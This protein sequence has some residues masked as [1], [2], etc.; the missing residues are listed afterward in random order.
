MGSTDIPPF[1]REKMKGKAASS[2]GNIPPFLKDKNPQAVDNTAPKANT[3]A[4][5]PAPTSTTPAPEPQVV[6]QRFK[7]VLSSDNILDR[8]LA[9]NSALSLSSFNNKQAPALSLTGFNQKQSS[10]LSLTPSFEASRHNFASVVKSN[11]E[12]IKEYKAKRLEQLDSEE[13]DHVATIERI[14]NET[15]NGL[16]LSGSQEE[17]DNASKKL[18]EVQTYK[19]ELVK[20]IDDQAAKTLGGL[21]PV[22]TPYLDETG[23]TKYKREYKPVGSTLNDGA[24]EAGKAVNLSYLKDMGK[25]LLEVTNPQEAAKFDMGGDTP[26]LSQQAEFMGVYARS[27]YL[28]DQIKNKTAELSSDPN[29]ANALNDYI[30]KKATKEQI[31]VLN[32]EGVK[33]LYDEYSTL[34]KYSNDI[35]HQFPEIRK[36]FLKKAIFNELDGRYGANNGF[37]GTQGWSEGQVNS[38]VSDYKKRLTD[39]RDIQLLDS[40]NE[41]KELGF[42]S[43]DNQSWAMKMAEQFGTT[44]WNTG[45]FLKEDVIKSA[46]PK[47]ASGILP[48]VS[49]DFNNINS[50]NRQNALSE[51]DAAKYTVNP[52]FKLDRKTFFLKE[53]V[54]TDPNSQNF[55][56]QTSDTSGAEGN[57][58]GKIFYNSA[59]QFGQ[60]AAQALTAAALPTIGRM[61]PSAAG[62]AENLVINKGATFLTKVAIPAYAMSYDNYYQQSFDVVGA[63]DGWKNSL[64]ASLLSS[65]EGATELLGNPLEQASFL[66]SSISDGV[67]GLIKNL[68]ADELEKMG[69][70]GFKDR[71]KSSLTEAGKGAA[72]GSVGA[73][74]ESNEEGL[75]D[76]LT[77]V[78]QAVFNPSYT[79]LGNTLNQ[80]GQ[81]WLET[82]AGMGFMP[83][84]GIAGGARKGFGSKLSQQATSFLAQNS[85]TARENIQRMLDNGDLNKNEAE[86]KTLLVNT[87]E[88]AHNDARAALRLSAPEIA[89]KANLDALTMARANELVVSKQIKTASDVVDDALKEALEEKKSKFVEMRKAILAN[90]VSFDEATGQPVPVANVPV[91]TVAPNATSTTDTSNLPVS[92]ANKPEITATAPVSESTSSADILPTPQV[93]TLT[94]VVDQRVAYNGSEGVLTKEGQ[95][96]IFQPD[97]SN[98]EYVIEPQDNYE[99]QPI[100]SLGLTKLTTGEA[101]TDSSLPAT[102]ATQ[103]APT[104]RSNENA[105]AIQA[106][107]NV[108]ETLTP[109][110][111]KRKKLYELSGRKFTPTKVSEVNLNND[112]TI[113]VRGDVYQNNYSDPFQAINRDEDG[114]V[115]SVNLETSDG[116]KRTFRGDTAN[117]IAYQMHLKEITKDDATRQSFEDFINNDAATAAEINDGATKSATEGSTNSNNGEISSEPTAGSTATGTSTGTGATSADTSGT[118]TAGAS[119]VGDSSAGSV[120]N[121]HEDEDALQRSFDKLSPAN[122]VKYGELMSEGNY[123]E[124]EALINE[125]DK[126]SLVAKNKIVK[127]N[128]SVT[129]SLS[130]EASVNELDNSVNSEPYK[131]SIIKRAKVIYDVVKKFIP[132]IEIFIHFDAAA[133]Q[134]ALADLGLD[135]SRSEA[136]YTYGN[137]DGRE[138]NR[139]DINLSVAKLGVVAHEATHAV[140]HKLFGNNKAAFNS[141]RGRISKILNESDDAH[142]TSFSN[143][144]L[145]EDVRDEEYLAELGALLQVRPEALKDIKVKDSILLKIK[146]LINSV[147]N[148]ALGKSLLISENDRISDVRDFFASMNTAFRTGKIDVN[149]IISKASKVGEVSD[150]NNTGISSKQS[151]LF[152]YEGSMKFREKG[153]SVALGDIVSSVDNPAFKPLYTWFQNKYSGDKKIHIYGGRGASEGLA[154]ADNKNKFIAINRNHPDI[155]TLK[156]QVK[157]DRVI[158]HEIIH[159]IIDDSIGKNIRLKKEFNSNL[160]DIINHLNKIDLSDVD[161]DVKKSIYFINKGNPEEIA[162]YALTDTK[163]AQFLDTIVYERNNS[164]KSNTVWGKIKDAILGLFNPNKDKSIL[165]AVGSVLDTYIGDFRSNSVFYKPDTRISGIVESYMQRAG[166]TYSP[167]PRIIKLDVEKSKRIADEYEA[168]KHDPI[169]PDVKAAYTAMANETIEQFRIIQSNYDIEVFKGNGEPYKSSKDVINDLIENNHLFIFATESGFGDGK[170]TDEQRAENPLLATTEFSDIQGVPLLV[171]DL[172]RAVHDAIGHGELGN[173]FGA[174]GEENAWAN[175]SRMYTP[176][177]RRAMTTETRGQNSWVNFS[178]S[179]IAATAKIAQG[180]KLIAQ[181]DKEEGEKI[182]KEGQDEFRFA[183]QKIGLL[184]EWV[185]NDK[186]SLTSRESLTPLSFEQRKKRLD[187]A[188]KIGA[189]TEEHYQKAISKALETTGAD[190]NVVLSEDERSAYDNFF[191]APE[192]NEPSLRERVANLVIPDDGNTSEYSAN[193]TFENAGFPQKGRPAKGNTTTI[194]LMVQANIDFINQLVS[195]NQN[196]I[197]DLME[198]FGFSVNNNKLA[199]DLNMEGVRTLNDYRLANVLYAYIYNSPISE[200]NLTPSQVASYT[201]Y[202]KKFSSELGREMG[203]SLNTAKMR[204]VADQVVN[205]L[206]LEGTLSANEYNAISEAEDEIVDILSGQAGNMTDEEL[207]AA[208]DDLFEIEKEKEN[209][210]K[211]STLLSRLMGYER[212]KE[213]AGGEVSEDRSNMILKDIDKKIKKTQQQIKDILNNIKCD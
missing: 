106:K 207:V 182:K 5:Q 19:Q 99:K 212:S 9:S 2:S 77:G 111:E 154:F 114:Y 68:S 3:D 88:V 165:D 53:R 74:G 76:L 33:S 213:K 197:H 81:T 91:T 168:M 46:I 135:T 119:Y 147:V 24:T 64:Y 118:S 117:D 82:L 200:L 150:G 59:S 34:D 95:Q 22:D 151:M 149:D 26:Y 185:S 202:L 73:I 47:L 35:T 62:A 208:D 143:R 130:S 72:R 1:L 14:N 186:S 23:K 195:E 92:D 37:L 164:V 56:Q 167:A 102:D 127:S 21:V 75:N 40:I 144:Y 79:T 166:I 58:L 113:S 32:S 110:E 205:D 27:K 4:A 133:M 28:E 52:N 142:L 44:L 196:A 141:F 43:G 131:R 54:E 108:G 146:N 134:L 96:Y 161:E 190:A 201:K 103:D 210:A 105:D 138:I 38:V 20:N 136:R 48:N 36:N 179:N 158:A 116:K 12:A 30:N 211:Q 65:F 193:K 203:Q 16:S 156:D 115:V 152:D 121:I 181:G 85:N 67:A 204:R 162:A 8:D 120:T 13:N 11:P 124:A 145:D 112:N 101:A 104:D 94:D 170:I 178:G 70:A 206:I 69:A 174:V 63:K 183:D 51:S 31:D 137:V 132:N 41:D 159:A 209:Q 15:I 18:A 177:A 153:A 60:L 45:K 97:N 90:K 187:T 84:T 100:E 160:T 17:K 184:P 126:A 39:P 109:D 123:D 89:T 29:K 175:H 49:N 125:V 192:K 129:A 6:E 176:L 50:E 107:I 71:L 122:K 180:N 173:G 80:A 87:A 83:A 93:T 198:H 128:E 66:K 148:K 199:R 194:P 171:N 191:K 7:D 172:F 86:Q 98:K 139:I 155:E 78:T 140:L 10:K 189:L 169:N 25:A 57:F 157:L 55:L 61:A 42:L 163:L 188:K